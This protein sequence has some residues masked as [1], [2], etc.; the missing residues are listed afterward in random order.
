MYNEDIKQRFIEDYGETSSTKTRILKLFNMASKFEKKDQKDI[1]FIDYNSIAQAI[2]N[3]TNVLS[4]ATFFDY[5][6]VFKRYKQWCMINGYFSD[7]NYYPM[8]NVSDLEL[9]EIYNRYM[10]ENI[11][12]T[13]EELHEYIKDFYDIDLEKDTIQKTDFMKLFI[14]LLYHGIHENDIFA[15]TTKNVKVQPN[16]I[17]VLYRNKIIKIEDNQTKQ[18]LRK[19]LRCNQ[20]EIDR[21]R[22]TE[23]VD[24]PQNLISYGGDDSEY[25]QTQTKKELARYTRLYN[26]KNNDNR[27]IQ[28]FNIY[29]SGLINQIKKNGEEISAKQLYKIFEENGYPEDIATRGKKKIIKETYKVW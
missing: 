2:L 12:R 18:L 20:Y 14:L 4:Y 24:L 25:N 29:T 15:L 19:R 21:G 17:F 11:F 5:I 6:S 3:E 23:F 13:I 1:Y 9:K 7:S 16:G 26:Q 28:F 10:S 22:W 27:K 8:Y